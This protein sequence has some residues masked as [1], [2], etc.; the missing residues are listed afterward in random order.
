M[1]KFIC[2][3]LLLICINL[4]VNAENCDPNEF[5]K[6]YGPY[7][8]KII[9]NNLHYKGDENATA[10]VSYYINN[11]G[12]VTDIELVEKSGTGFDEALIQA[13]QK[14]AP[15]K[16]FPEE[17]NISSVRLTSQFQH[18]V[19]K[20]QAPVNIKSENQQYVRMGILPVE[21]PA[22]A[23]NA[24]NDYVKKIGKYLFDRI[25]TTYSYVPKEP[26]L[27][28]IIKKDGTL[29]DVTLERTS[30]I[31]EYDKKIIETYSNMK[32]QP[33]PPELSKYYEEI[34][35]SATMIRQFRTSPAFNPSGF[36][37]K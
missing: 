19:Y 16:P 18:A 31:E 14:S 12:S 25:P 4:A 3:L 24:Y 21:P 28:C 36:I 15:F 20:Y 29:K 11:D 6:E 23:Q 17:L 30:G 9:K 13:V 22:E 27:K 33:F 8:Q 37:F 1:K 7:V 2:F 26:V 32:I 34:P 10:T 5:I 35:Y